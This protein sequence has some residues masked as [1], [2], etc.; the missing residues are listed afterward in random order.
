MLM[1]TRD[2][3]PPVMVARN[4]GT[5]KA[6]RPTSGCGW[7]RAWRSARYPAP[8]LAASAGSTVSAPPPPPL[9]L[10]PCPSWSK[11]NS[12]DASPSPFSANPRASN[13]RGSCSPLSRTR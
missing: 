2:T 10:P 11:A 6:S 5:A 9:P 8:K 4:D 12:R 1:D 7:R 13:G 3:N